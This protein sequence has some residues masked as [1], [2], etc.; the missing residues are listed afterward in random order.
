MWT[1]NRPVR[2][3]EFE[4]KIVFLEFFAVWCP[5]CVAAANET[6]PRILDHY[7][8]LKGTS[9]GLEVVFI[10]VNIEA[11]TA[12]NLQPRTDDF[13]ASHGY[14][15]VCNDYLRTNNTVL[16]NGVVRALFQPRNQPVFVAINGVT[17]SPSHRPWELLINYLGYG[18]TDF[19]QTV[20]N[21]RAVL[22]SVQA[23]PPR[24]TE[25]RH[26]G[27][28]FGFT[29][30]GQRGRTNVVECTTNF[31]DWFTVT[32]VFGTNAPVRVI[33]SG[34][35]NKDPRFYRVNRP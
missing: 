2:L 18:Q 28:A 6:D 9:N 1:T 15:L 14:P 7:A 25:P 24:I 35:T 20:T 19:R 31:M 3:R 17:N 11:S 33:D 23:P 12:S 26:E 27:D 16:S 21:F 22:D 32:N 4:G 13:V 8:S 29:I 10:A 30:P 34:A 5:F